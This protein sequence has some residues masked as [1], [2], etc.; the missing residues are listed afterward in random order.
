MTEKVPQVISDYFSEKAKDKWKK[1]SKKDRKEHSRKMLEAKRL[2][3]LN[4]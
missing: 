1:V 4:K 2:K 3:K